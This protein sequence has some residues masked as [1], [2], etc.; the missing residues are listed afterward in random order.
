[1]KVRESK[2]YEEVNT[3][4]A[5]LVWVTVG[6]TAALPSVQSSLLFYGITKVVSNGYGPV[7]LCRGYPCGY[8][9]A[10]KA[11]C[12]KPRSP[13]SCIAIFSSFARVFATALPPVMDLR[14]HSREESSEVD[15]PSSLLLFSLREQG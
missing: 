8:K 7:S 10:G 2:Q 1:M 11:H 3:S 13:A 9:S 14:K 12:S 15:G 6:E 4:R 5:Y